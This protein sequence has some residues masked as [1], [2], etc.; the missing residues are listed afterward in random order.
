MPN[1]SQLSSDVRRQNAS[2]P[3]TVMN[4]APSGEKRLES[5][6]GGRST[7]ISTQ[8]PG[9]ERIRPN[10]ILSPATQTTNNSQRQEAAQSAGRG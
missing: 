3:K 8:R 1:I 5:E 4:R 10:A 7:A 2:P 6:D 9:Q